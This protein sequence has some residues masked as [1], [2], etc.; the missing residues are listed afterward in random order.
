MDAC[1]IL[2]TVPASVPGSFFSHMIT[3][4]KELMEVKLERMS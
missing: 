4:L 1:F 2:F 3:H